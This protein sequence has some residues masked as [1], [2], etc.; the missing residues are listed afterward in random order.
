MVKM[1]AILKSK[2]AAVKVTW[3]FG[4]I[5]FCIPWCLDFYTW[6]LQRLYPKKHMDSRAWQTIGGGA[7]SLEFLGRRICF[8]SFCERFQK[9]IAQVAHGWVIS[10]DV[11]A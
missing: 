2:M 7:N 3:K 4:N 8:C 5:G 6:K 11:Q 9:K 10:D 1:A